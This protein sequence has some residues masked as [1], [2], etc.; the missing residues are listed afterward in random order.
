MADEI[1]VDQEEVVTPEEAPVETPAEV[2][3]PEEPVAS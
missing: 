2:A 3:A 1:P